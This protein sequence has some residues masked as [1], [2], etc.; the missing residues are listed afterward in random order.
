MAP[1]QRAVEEFERITERHRYE[2]TIFAKR[3]L[4]NDAYRAEDAVQTAFMNAWEVWQTGVTIIDARAW[5]YR[6]VRNV[7]YNIRRSASSR[8]DVKMT[9]NLAVPDDLEQ[10]VL[11]R[12][13]LRNHLVDITRLPPEQKKALLDTTL[14]GRSVS[15]VGNDLG[16][17]DGAV[18]MLIWRARRELERKPFDS[19]R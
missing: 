18:R 1:S 9:E 4:S 19:R 11:G 14:G 10:M 5:L 8:Y 13:R 12:M 16:I 2:L 15:D 7:S 3:I 6:I 17:T